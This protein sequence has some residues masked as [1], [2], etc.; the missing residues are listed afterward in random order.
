MYSID[1]LSS[2]L[3]ASYGAF[4]FSKYLIIRIAICRTHFHADLNEG[5]NV[6]SDLE[7]GFRID[8]G[9]N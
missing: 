7:K 6:F 8:D 1:N 5:G 2:P 4:N 3:F 9:R